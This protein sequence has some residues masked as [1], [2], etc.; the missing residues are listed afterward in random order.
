MRTLVLA[1]A[2]LVALLAPAVVYAIN[3][4]VSVLVQIVP[5]ATGGVACDVG[6]PYQGS[7]PGPAAAMGFT[8]CLN[9]DF[10]FTGT[11]SSKYYYSHNSSGVSAPNP[12][13]PGGAV[14]QWSDF[15]SW[16]RDAG[17]SYPLMYL[18]N[19]PSDYGDFYQITT[20]GG[21]QVLLSSA[22]AGGPYANQQMLTMD[23]PTTN[24][25]LEEE[26]RVS[27]TAYQG[28]TSNTNGEVIDDFG[29]YD[30]PDSGG[31]E[32][33]FGLGCALATPSDWSDGTACGG[34]GSF[35]WFEGSYGQPS[36]PPCCGINLS[37]GNYHTTGVLWTSSRTNGRMTTCAYY[38]QQ[39]AQTLGYGPCWQPWTPSGSPL[40]SNVYA[41]TLAIYMCSQEGWQAIGT[42]V[43][44]ATQVA[45]QHWV[46][47]IT[48]W[49][50]PGWNT[51]GNG[52]NNTCDPGNNTLYGGN[53]APS[54]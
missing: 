12:A 16:L 24:V 37:D 38:D 51:P 3:P 26:A 39:P 45:G 11:F 48:I 28:V 1:L 13:A 10:T 50:C 52:A 4:S 27:P 35:I 31:M 44:S 8:S 5:V 7:I 18:F 42:F 36:F 47:R 46:R 22:P 2:A 49:T 15:S 25:F 21:T 20:D 40:G 54:Y 33:D 30:N 9:Y 14:Y 19:S 43:N 29:F 41:C 17:A 23:F 34:N 32:T 6:P 53:D